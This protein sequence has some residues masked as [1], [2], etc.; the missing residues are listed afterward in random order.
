M[1]YIHST[2]ILSHSL[3]RVHRVAYIRN[4]E[5]VILAIYTQLKQDTQK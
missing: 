1:Y 5:T 4:T 2:L 3:I